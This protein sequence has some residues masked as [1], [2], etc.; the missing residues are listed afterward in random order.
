[1]TIEQAREQLNISPEVEFERIIKKFYSYVFKHAL[2]KLGNMADAEEMTQEI[3]Q[4]LWIELKNDTV[5]FEEEKKIYGYL[6]ILTRNKCLD[7]IR[8][9]QGRGKS[10]IKRVFIPLRD[11]PEQNNG[12]WDESILD[13]MFAQEIIEALTDPDNKVCT[14][15]EAE[16]LM[17]LAVGCTFIELK[18]M[19]NVSEATVN[20]IR[21]Q[22]LKKIREWLEII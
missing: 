6:L 16:V 22:A 18:N 7:V 19:L 10:G 20:N 3:F 17:S 2:E 21:K 11:A 13:A 1:M 15:R 5:N 9:R 14:Q 12:V 4:S 8:S